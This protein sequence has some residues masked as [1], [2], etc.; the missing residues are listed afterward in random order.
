MEGFVMNKKLLIGLCLLLFS[1][2]AI[3]SC[4]GAVSQ[5]LDELAAVQVKDYQGEDLSSITDFRENSILGPQII[6]INEYRL[7]VDGLVG[8][9]K[10]YKYDKVLTEFPNYKK[11]VTLNCVEGWSVKILWEG[12]L[13][14]DIL[15]ASNPSPDGTVVIF[16]AYDGYTTSLPLQYIMDNNIMLA[17]KMNDV[18]LPAERGFPFQLVAEEKWGYK[19]IKWVTEI[20]LSDDENYHGYWEQRGYSNSADLDES[21]FG[22]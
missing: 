19:W 20:E 2:A 6:D 16:H 18:V 13:V 17:Y 12:V 5:N 7:K 1:A 4:T 14:E 10:E 11:V 9:K 21:F 3:T 22:R 15:K 8:D